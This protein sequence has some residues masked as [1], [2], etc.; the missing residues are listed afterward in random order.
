MELTYWLTAQN[1]AMIRGMRP[2][3]FMQH[4]VD[5]IKAFAAAPCL[6]PD[7]PW[8]PADYRQQFTKLLLRAQGLTASLAKKGS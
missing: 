5:A 6:I 4:A 3:A 8:L 1:A 7:L 2:N